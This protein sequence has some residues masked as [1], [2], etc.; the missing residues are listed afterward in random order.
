V[1]FFFM[2]SDRAAFIKLKIMQCMKTN[3]VLVCLVHFESCET[4]NLTI[5]DEK[6]LL[7]LQNN[8]DEN[9]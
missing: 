5:F 2:S 1:V 9:C 6:I 3:T 7:A 4:G 8:R